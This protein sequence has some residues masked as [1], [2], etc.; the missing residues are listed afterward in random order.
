M[1][2]EFNAVNLARALELLLELGYA[3]GEV[4]IKKGNA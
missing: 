1:V 4:L 2:Q 3:G